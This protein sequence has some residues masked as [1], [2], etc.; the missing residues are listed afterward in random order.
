MSDLKDYEV[1]LIGDFNAHHHTW[2]LTGKTNA[3]GILLYQL[4]QDEQLVVVNAPSQ[5]C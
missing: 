5:P 4:L 2:S 1:I 3:A